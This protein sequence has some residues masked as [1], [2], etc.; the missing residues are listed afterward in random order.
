M[1]GSARPR[2]ALLAASEALSAAM[3]ETVDAAE[4]QN[5]AEAGAFGDAWVQGP[6]S[7]DL[8]YSSEAGGKKRVDGEVVGRADA[9]VFPD[10]LSANLTVKGSCTRRHADLAG[11][12]RHDRPGRLHVPVDTTATRLNSLSLALALLAIEKAPAAIA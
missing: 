6:L 11:P 4:I 7:F 1:L 3:P 5:L 10:L 12:R 9:L 8:A 2:V